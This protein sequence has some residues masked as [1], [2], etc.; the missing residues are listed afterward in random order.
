MARAGLGGPLRAWRAPGP[1][2]WPTLEPPVRAYGR[3][4]RGQTRQLP[5][6]GHPRVAA[7]GGPACQRG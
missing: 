5:W 7:Q 2:C 4:R 3:P 6:A 1:R